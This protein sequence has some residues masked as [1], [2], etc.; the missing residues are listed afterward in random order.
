[1]RGAWQWKCGQDESQVKHKCFI[2]ASQLNCITKN[3]F[4]SRIYNLK[5]HKCFI[6]NFATLLTCWHVG[7]R[8]LRKCPRQFINKLFLVW[9]WWEGVLWM[10]K[11][12]RA[13]SGHTPHSAGGGVGAG[14][15]SALSARTQLLLG[16]RRPVWPPS[17][18]RPGP[19]SPA[20]GLREC[21][22][23]PAPCQS[24]PRGAGEHTLHSHH[25]QHHRSRVQ[26]ASPLS[27]QSY[28]H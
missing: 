19:V 10:R 13:C 26:T 21:C 11:S 27:L 16:P 22:L 20:A 3:I 4:L 17:T 1:M 12:E 15:I 5:L 6:V 25:C 9:W 18:H 23:S 24:C 2:F 7:T 14:V 28:H 8:V